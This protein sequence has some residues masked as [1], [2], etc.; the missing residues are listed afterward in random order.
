MF[1]NYVKTS[2]EKGQY[3]WNERHGSTVYVMTRILTQN[4]RHTYEILTEKEHE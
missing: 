2:L 3:H 4:E 1:G